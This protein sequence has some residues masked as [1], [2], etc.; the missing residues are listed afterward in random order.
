MVPL[1]SLGEIAQLFLKLGSIG[2]GG[3]QA[4]IAMMSDEVVERRGWLTAEEFSEG[5][6]ICE[7]LPGPASTQM[8]IYLG[9]CRAGHLGAWVAGICFIA[10]AFVIV[11]ALS[12]AYFRWQAIPQRAGI[13]LG[14]APVVGAIVLAFCW[15]LGRKTLTSWPKRAI[16]LATLL[17]TLFT[18]LTL[19]LQFPLAGVVG[20]WLYRPRRDPK[21]G[22]SLLGIGSLLGW[23]TGWGLEQGKGNGLGTLTAAPI[24]A[25]LA[26][27]VSLWGGERLFDHGWP[28]LL[29]F[30]K[31]GL[32]IFGG[33]LVVIPL[34]EQGVVQ[35]FQWLSRE[36]FINGVAIG[37][38]TPGPVVLTA[39]FVGYRVAGLGGALVAT[40]GIFA[41]SFMFILGA[42]PL[43]RRLRQNPYVKAFLQGVTPAVLGAIAAAAIPLAQAAFHQPRAIASGVAVLIGVLAWVA[44]V[45]YQRPPWQLVPL[46]AV[47]GLV[48][49]PVVL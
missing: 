15:K 1:R 48:L 17:A 33:G 34:L 8:G 35:E 38:I 24:A 20:L 14:I 23:G 28:L 2:F 10:P 44:L 4:H 9:Y 45:Y 5:L 42:A 18:P 46:A 37:Q 16:A 25:P 7:M 19:M 22:S 3:P 29:F 32:L 36:E 6:A 39:A 30:F 27:E 47:V 43:L 40:L 49:G 11:V 31:A 13:F 26:A 21:S 41:P 12:W